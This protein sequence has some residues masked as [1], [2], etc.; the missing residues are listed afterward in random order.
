LLREPFSFPRTLSS[1]VNFLLASVKERKG[2]TIR[3]CLEMTVKI[4]AS[5]RMVEK[6]RFERRRETKESERETNQ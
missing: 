3:F 2:L 1:R 6:D 5:Q 4:H